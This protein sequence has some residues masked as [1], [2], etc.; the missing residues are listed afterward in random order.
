MHFYSVPFRAF[1]FEA[2]VP[3]HVPTYIPVGQGRAGGGAPVDEGAPPTPG[4]Q[5]VAVG[6]HRGGGRK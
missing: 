4:G 1:G 3:A 2:T 6:G 5:V